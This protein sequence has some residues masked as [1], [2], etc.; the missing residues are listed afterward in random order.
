[1][2]LP[3]VMQRC[4]PRIGLCALLLSGAASLTIAATAPVGPH[5]DGPPSAAAPPI[6]HQAQSTTSSILITARDDLSDPN[7][8]GSTVLVLNNIAEGPAGLIINRPM[9][10]PVSR[11]FPDLKALAGLQDKLYFGGPVEFGSS[12]WFLFRARTQ[13]RHAVQACAGVYLSADADLLR[14]LLS[15]P[16]PMAGLRIFVGY[17]GW[18]PG[19]LQAEIAS[20]AWT[21]RRAD[22]AGI[23]DPSSQR[24]WPPPRIPGKSTGSTAST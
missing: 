7:F 13:P 21:A 2:P 3:R 11:L 6:A 17:A 10:V 1:M 12:V 23:F 4:S 14:Q 24:P 16:D 19:Q 5:A 20:G 8:A 18:G 15:R 9:A 22:A